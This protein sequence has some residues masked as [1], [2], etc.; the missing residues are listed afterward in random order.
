MKL[1]AGDSSFISAQHKDCNK[2]QTDLLPAAEKVDAL[3]LLNKYKNLGVKM[4]AYGSG[5]VFDC[6]MTGSSD[7]L[8]ALAVRLA[9][10]PAY[11]QYAML[12]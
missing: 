12:S 11:S 3:S 2:T 9:V 4:T 7:S 6:Y 10:C 8:E 1:Q 5:E